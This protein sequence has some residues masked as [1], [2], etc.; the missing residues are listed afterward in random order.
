[1]EDSLMKKI[2]LILMTAFA[3]A[4]VSCNKELPGRDDNTQIAGKNT[5]VARFADETKTAFVGGTYMWKQNDNMVVRSDNANG[6]TTYKYTGDDTAGEVEFVPNTDDNVVYGQ[7]SFAIYPAK[8]SGSG[9]NAYPKEEDGSL[10]PVLKDTYTWFDGNVEAPMLARVEAG[11]PLEFKH[12][13]GCLKVTYKNVPPKATKIVVYAPVTDADLIAA[14][15]VS[16]KINSTMNKT[17]NWTTADGGFDPV[18][19]PYVKA[20]D[21]SGTYK[22]VVNFKTKATADNRV[23]GIT[24][25]IPLPVG[26]VEIGGKNVYP[27]LDVCLAFDDDTVVPGS[28]RK[29]SNVQIERAHIK[30]M[31]EV[32]LTKYSV[33]IVAGADNA[34]ATTDGTGT[35]ARFKQVRGFAWLNNTTLGLIE[36]NSKLIRS[37]NTGSAA[38]ATLTTS[39][40]GS[41]PW[42]GE[43]KDGLL[44]I[45]DKGNKHIYSFNPSTNAITDVKT[46][47]YSPMEI[48]FYG[49][50]AY[51]VSR[52]ASKVYKYTGG[53]A[54]GTESVFF[55]FS[56][57]DLGTTSGQVNWPLAMCF[58]A[59]GNALVTLGC[60][61]GGS[62]SAYKVYVINSSGAIVKEIGKGGTNLG[63]AAAITDGAIA[64]AQFTANPNAIRLG[65][66]GAVY[67]GERGAIRRITHSAADYSDAVVTTILGCGSSYAGTSGANINI[68]WSSGI[69]DLIFDPVNPKVFYYFDFRYTLRKVTI[70]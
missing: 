19:V 70:E 20:Y 56:T 13:G 1:M 6:Y 15:K 44:Y 14:G 50:D 45:A 49:S 22:T 10:K 47:S 3:V 51:V 65:P 8:T 17:Y 35:A 33:E 42:H 5:L 29:A 52:D 28:L 36:T 60:S 30:P 23:N 32:S 54:T 61:K 69:Q 21:H 11:Q 39:A 7:N 68:D 37:F 59:D 48:H 63:S 57:L 34:A 43:M 31:P 16:Y 46:L 9:A 25:Y 53:I 55:D 26:P 4:A 24:A 18:E 12:L 40:F 27:E 38:V 67:V 58:D 2:S 41:A 64:N 66:D 62:P